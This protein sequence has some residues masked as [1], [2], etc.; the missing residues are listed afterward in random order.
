MLHFRS[1]LFIFFGSHE[2]IGYKIFNYICVYKSNSYVIE[3]NNAWVWKSEKGFTEKWFRL[4]KLNI[5]K[6]R[7]RKWMACHRSL[8]VRG[9]N[10]DDIGSMAF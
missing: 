10:D 6:R 8:I 9:R 4:F 1:S 3:C 2:A 7:L 5:L